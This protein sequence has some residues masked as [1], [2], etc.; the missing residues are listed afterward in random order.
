[1][2]SN[3]W[4]VT[5]SMIMLERATVRPCTPTLMCWERGTTPRCNTVVRH[6]APG[7]SP[8]ALPTQLCIEV[9]ELSLLSSLRLYSIQSV[10]PASRRTMT[11]LS[12][13]VHSQQ[14]K[15]AARQ[16]LA[17]AAA[18]WR[19][20]GARGTCS[21]HGNVFILITLHYCTILV[22]NLLV[23]LVIFSHKRSKETLLLLWI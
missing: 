15:I 16:V 7:R 10:S 14:N 8:S 19:L 2:W 12:C 4:G 9:V 22:K 18:L 20:P 5:L 17:P 13:V 23:F 11:Q 1:M 6:T 21:S 3:P